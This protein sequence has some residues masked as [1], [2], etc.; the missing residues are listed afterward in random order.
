MMFM[1]ERKAPKQAPIPTPELP[2]I[3]QPEEPA[4]V[5][6]RRRGCPTRGRRADGS[7]TKHGRPTY[8]QAAKIVARFGGEIRLAEALGVSRVT[9]YRWSYSHPY[10]SDGLVPSRTVAAV[11]RAARIEGIV[12]TVGDW[13]P[14]RIYYPTEGE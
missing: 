11:Q 7:V 14:E 1:S 13:T 2:P 12:L 3:L 5:E 4:E 6:P 9:V 8:N 10:G